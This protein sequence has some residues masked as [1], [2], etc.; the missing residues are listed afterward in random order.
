MHGAALE[1]EEPLEFVDTQVAIMPFQL[2]DAKRDQ[3]ARQMLPLS[4]LET[5]VAAIVPELVLTGT[6][7]F[8]DVGA[9]PLSAADLRSG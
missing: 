6:D 7:D 3:T 5:C 1:T 2:Q 8:R 4:P 9:P